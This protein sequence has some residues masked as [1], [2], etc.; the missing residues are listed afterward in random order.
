MHRV[1]GWIRAL[2]TAEGRVQRWSLWLAVGLIGCVARRPTE[3]GL[4][5]WYG[6]GFRGKPTASG[7]RFVPW[8]R[9]AAHRTLPFG[10][11]LRVER[12]DTGQAVRVVVND[13]GPFV[14]GRVVDLSKGA[15]RRVDM[16]KDGVVPV[17]VRVVG[18]R[19]RR[20]PC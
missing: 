12:T 19:S 7:E 4:A 9:T 1:C 17:Q 10:T 6:P 20:G 15:A 11:V 3:T 8:K 16:L 5:S 14:A 18:C 2:P 13:R